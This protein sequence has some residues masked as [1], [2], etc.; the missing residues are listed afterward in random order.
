M[1]L[2]VQAMQLQALQAR[3]QAVISAN[4]LTRL[5]NPLVQSSVDALCQAAVAGVIRREGKQ[6]A[7]A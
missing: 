3:V 5:R 7:T 6:E 2:K 4:R 1:L